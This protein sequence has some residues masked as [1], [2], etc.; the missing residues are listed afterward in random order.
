MTTSR[1]R[2]LTGTLISLTFGITACQRSAAVDTTRVEHVE[3]GLLPAISIRGIS[4]PPP[5]KLPDRMAY[6]RVPGVSVAI[7]NNGE[8][9]WA[10][11]YGTLTASSP[12]P[13][14]RGLCFRRH[15]SASPSPHWRLWCSSRAA[16]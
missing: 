3:N 4:A 9:E 14:Q 11:G 12:N 8:L 2:R 15:Q 7:I 6:Y 16:G 1:S 13:V 10:K 5:M